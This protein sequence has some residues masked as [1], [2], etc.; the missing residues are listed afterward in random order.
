MSMMMERAVKVRESA[1]VLKNVLFAVKTF[2]ADTMSRSL[3]LAG[4]EEIHLFIISAKI[5]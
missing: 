3:F 5:I 1:R 4:A 2:A